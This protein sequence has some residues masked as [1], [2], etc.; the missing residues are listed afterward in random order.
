VLAKLGAETASS[1]DEIATGM[2]KFAAIGE[3]VGLSYNNAAAAL[4]TITATTRQSADVVGTAL[5]TL[6]SR[7]E[8]LKLGETLDDGTTLGKYSEALKIA[9]VN[10]KDANGEL[11]DMDDIIDET[12]KKW[13]TLSRDQQVA[14]AQS[15][16]GIRQYTQFMALMDNYDMYGKLVNSAENATGTLQE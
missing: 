13:Q 4:A 9:G 3:T 5:K 7:M 8:Q 14:L 16:A 12:G 11:K 15:V 10:I 2:E 1:A 6:F